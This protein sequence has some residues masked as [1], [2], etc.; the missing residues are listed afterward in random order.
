MIRS[1]TVEDEAFHHPGQLWEVPALLGHGSYKLGFY[2]LLSVCKCG[3][4]SLVRS[5]IKQEFMCFLITQT[6]QLGLSICDI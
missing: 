3:A 6:G 5:V 2:I 1:E 4:D